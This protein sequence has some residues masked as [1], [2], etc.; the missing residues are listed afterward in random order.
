MHNSFPLIDQ[1]LSIRL[2][3]EFTA[4]LPGVVTVVETPRRLVAEEH[5]SYVRA[6]WWIW[7][8][9][10]RS[11]LS[12]PPGMAREIAPVIAGI[13]NPHRLLDSALATALRGLID[14]A[15]TEA[16]L[17]ATTQ[18]YVDYC[19][20]C[21]AALLRRHTGGEC[22]RLTDEQIPPAE[23]LWWP[24]YC[25]SDGIAFGVIAD[26]RVVSIAYAHRTAIMPGQVAD[27]AVCTAQPY[28]R[29]GFARTA[30]SALVEHIACTGGE[31][32]YTCAVDN[33]A[34]IATAR[35][36]GFAEHGISLLMLSPI[37]GSV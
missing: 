37:R 19:F 10:G 14:C 36:V 9:D 6:L 1:Q 22:R 34:S 29:R 11:V 31:T 15:L 4:L 30:V 32:R 3:C 12:V 13:D 28:C 18:L 24:R 26:R 7:L 23:G 25:F 33:P 2:D 8:A 20:A 35:S 17:P 21:N 27:V 5:F 16:G